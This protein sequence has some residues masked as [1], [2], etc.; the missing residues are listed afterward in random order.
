MKRV[1]KNTDYANA[2]LSTCTSQLP[3][4]LGIESS[5][6]LGACE[7]DALKSYTDFQ[8][9]TAS[10]ADWVVSMVAMIPCIQVCFP[11][12]F[13]IH[14][15]L[16][17]NGDS[18]SYYQIAMDL[19]DSS[20]HKGQRKIIT[21]FQCIANVLSPQTLSGTS[22]G[23]RRTPNT[24]GLLSGREVGTLL[25]SPSEVPLTPASAFFIENSYRWKSQ[26]EK[27]NEIF[28]KACQGEIDFWAVALSNSES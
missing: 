25:A 22:C 15:S 7:S 27:V 10:S 11:P 14:G 2:I 19:K 16:T 6:V 5:T 20:T 21:N 23:F 26:Y 17:S 18:Q 4:G 13:R 8:I 12:F 3:G 1:Q 24:K 9:S 28:R